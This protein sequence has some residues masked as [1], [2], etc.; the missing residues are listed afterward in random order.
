MIKKTIRK[1]ETLLADEHIGADELPPLQEVI[2]TFPLSISDQLYALIDKNDENDPIKK[3]FVPSVQELNITASES[4]DPIGDAVHQ[5]VKG[6]IHRYPD[7]CLFLPVQVCPVY[8]RFCF[9]REQVGDSDQTLSKPEQEA[10]YSYIESQKNIWEVILT[11]G[12]PLILKPAILRSIVQRLNAIPH[13]EVIRIHT[14]IPIVESSR[15]NDEMIAALASKKPI[16]VA[17]HANHAK[18][19]SPE[20][21]SALARLANAGIALISQTTLLRG[22]NDNIDALGDLMRAFVKH[23]VKPYYLHHPDLAKGTSHFR[24]SIKE[25]QALMQ[26][27]RGRFS[28]LCQPTYMLD[29]PGGYGKVPIGP[30]YLHQCDEE[31]GCTIEDYQ[32]NLHRYLE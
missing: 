26:Q 19:F 12:D 2:E 11:G 20:A 10:A 21:I 29:I 23:R 7:R 18:E 32:G 5:A 8:C 14:R 24:V 1:L 25:G 3:Q 31:G 9:R 27:L 15:I 16:Y 17:V 28:G 22:V 30:Q 4:A 13:V 6:V